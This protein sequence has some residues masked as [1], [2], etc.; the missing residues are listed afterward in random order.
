L[1]LRD[2]CTVE[3]I[4]MNRWDI[5]NFDDVLEENASGAKPIAASRLESVPSIVYRQ[6]RETV[7]RSRSAG[8]G[9]HDRP[10]R[11]IAQLKTAEMAAS[12]LG[13]SLAAL[14]TCIVTDLPC[15]RAASLAFTAGAAPLLVVTIGVEFD[16]RWRYQKKAVVT[17][18]PGRRLLR[19]APLWARTPGTP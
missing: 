14:R 3:R 19:V 15:R 9:T 13:P 17:G 10:R 2:E 12:A 8:D 16:S 1:S 4:A 11:V 18:F 5:C 6:H 7:M